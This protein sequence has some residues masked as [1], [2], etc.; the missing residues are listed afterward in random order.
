MENERYSLIEVFDN[1]MWVPKSPV[2]VLQG[3][4]IMDSLVGQH[5]LQLSLLSSTD[6]RISSV[7]IDIFCYDDQG[8]P[9]FDEPV[10]VIYKDIINT[11]GVAFGEDETHY[12]RSGRVTKVQCFVTRVVYG[13]GRVWRGQDEPVRISA[14]DFD[15]LG[16]DLKAI[17]NELLKN[18]FYSSIDTEYRFLPRQDEHF[19][20]CTCG[21]ANENDNTSCQR[22]GMNRTWIMQNLNMVHLR[23]ILDERVNKARREA[24]DER[25]KAAAAKQAEEAIVRMQTAAVEEGIKTTELVA[26]PEAAES[27]AQAIIDEFEVSE[28]PPILRYI[29]LGVLGVALIG[30]GVLIY[31]LATNRINFG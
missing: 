20:V 27:E 16:D 29:I 24:E 11:K 14:H 26:Q 7:Y 12:L 2:E 15:E 13:D 8:E 3:A 10:S 17:F 19:W 30:T 9:I 31:L 5:C 18:S 4:L 22:C 23:H 28:K 25:Q 21:R 1:D 6:K